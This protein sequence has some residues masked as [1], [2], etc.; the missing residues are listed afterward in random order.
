MCNKA[1]GKLHQEEEVKPWAKAKAKA[2]AKASNESSQAGKARQG[3]DEVKPNHGWR[4]A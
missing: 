4:S 3:G 1:P 2:K